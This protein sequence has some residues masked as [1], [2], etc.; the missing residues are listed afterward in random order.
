MDADPPPVTLTRIRNEIRRFNF[1]N[2]DEFELHAGLET[3][4]TGLGLTVEREVRLDQ[5][6][7]IDIATDLPAGLRLG[8]EVKIAGQGMNVLRQVRRYAAVP[9]LDALMLV[10][11]INRHLQAV[12]PWVDVPAGP[13]SMSRWTL[14]G[15]PFDLV[16]L[17]RGLL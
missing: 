5:H 3:I 15:K 1:R 12:M 9:E 6:S 4:L 13:P 14:D 11:T 8:I 2:A 17:R 16:L 7:R 10:T